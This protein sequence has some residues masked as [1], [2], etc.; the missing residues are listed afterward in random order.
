[1]DSFKGRKQSR[2]RHTGPQNVL[3]SEVSKNLLF[4]FLL[5]GPCPH[6]SIPVEMDESQD[7][8]CFPLCEPCSGHTGA[9]HK[10][11]PLQ[12]AAHNVGQIRLPETRYTHQPH[13]RPPAPAPSGHMKHLHPA[14]ASN[15]GPRQH[16][17]QYRQDALGLSSRP[18]G[19]SVEESDYLEPPQP[20]KSNI[21]PRELVISGNIIVI[22]IIIHQRPFLI[23]AQRVG[24]SSSDPTVALLFV[25]N[26]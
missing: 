18:W 22:I 21:M 14:D 10:L 16:V 25:V 23:Q 5:S 12:Q 4:C 3:F 9:S 11:P 2:G 6:Q 26:M 19:P 8:D 20:L 17:P 7:L 13:T 1:M 15:L 24:V